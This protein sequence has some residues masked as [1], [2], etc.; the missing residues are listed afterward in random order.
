[1]LV[2][3]N[4]FM[5][6]IKTEVIKHQNHFERLANVPLSRELHRV[7]HQGWDRTKPEFFSTSMLPRSELCNS[8]GPRWLWGEFNLK[9]ATYYQYG[10][11]GG[12]LLFKP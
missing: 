4:Q 10:P 3:K 2:Y 8:L 12:K 11:A 9:I 5:S 6:T 7:I 1:M